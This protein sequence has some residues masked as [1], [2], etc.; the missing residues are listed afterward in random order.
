MMML[1]LQVVKT[2]LLKNSLVFFMAVLI[3][4]PL[5]WLAVRSAGAGHGDYLAAIW[6]FPFPMV[7]S[8]FNRHISDW[9]IAVA[10][11][12]FPAYTVVATLLT[13]KYGWRV[14]LLILVT[15]H[16]IGVAAFYLFA[17]GMG[18]F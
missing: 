13:R 6:L 10:C 17:R 12:Q 14:V 3:T 18:V 4:P 5:L 7:L 16:L 8:A 11:V 1:K 2:T 15:S 9:I